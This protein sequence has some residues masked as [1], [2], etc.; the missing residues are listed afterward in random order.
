MSPTVA[1]KVRLPQIELV[2][3]SILD[4]EGRPVSITI[5]RLDEIEVL[6]AVRS[7]PGTMPKTVEEAEQDAAR[8]KWADFAAS[9]LRAR[10]VL[11]RACVLVDE[12]GAEVQAFSFESGGPG[13]IPWRLLRTEDKV[14]VFKTTMEHHGYMG[15]AVDQIRFPDGG[16]E[17]GERVEP[18]EAVRGDGDESA[19]AVVPGA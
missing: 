14:A 13:V 3:A 12:A 16:G 2:L 17:L 10:T 11:E 4:D 5:N 6:A 9:V 8:D 7:Q 1:S 18:L 19:P 15:G